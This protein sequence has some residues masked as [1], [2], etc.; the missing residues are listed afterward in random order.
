[1]CLEHS[2]G[3]SSVGCTHKTAGPTSAVN[4]KS[5]IKSWSCGILVEESSVKT[6][7][8]WMKVIYRTL[9]MRHGQCWFHIV[10]HTSSLF[11]LILQHVCSHAFT[12]FH[13][14]PH[15][16]TSFHR[17]L[18]AYSIFF[19]YFHMFTPHTSTGFSHILPQ[20]SSSYF[21]R[22]GTHTATFHW[23]GQCG[24]SQIRLLMEYPAHAKE[25]Q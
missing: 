9:V 14:L 6:H 22:L 18:P 25:P 16:S 5:L 19:T 2:P 23:S 15:P 3:A 10:T 7:I 11:L 24:R 1:M 17:F 4:H 8:F 20:V 13:I 21:N 12:Y